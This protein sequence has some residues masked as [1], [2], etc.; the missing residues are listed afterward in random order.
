MQ[1]PPRGRALSAGG[2]QG[3]TENRKVITGVVGG[4]P[5]TPEVNEVTLDWL[6]T[7]YH[8]TVFCFSF[9]LLLIFLFS[10]SYKN[11]FLMV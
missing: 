9:L 8:I 4:W 5:L 6:L 10:D 1:A 3:C 11:G 7:F 2:V